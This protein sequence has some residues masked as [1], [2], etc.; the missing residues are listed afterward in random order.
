M[1]M[2]EIGKIFHQDTYSLEMIFLTQPAPR[3]NCMFDPQIN[4][5]LSSIYI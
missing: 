4:W 5:Y 3:I 2:I 1:A